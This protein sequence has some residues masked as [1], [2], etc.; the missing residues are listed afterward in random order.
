[1]SPKRKISPLQSREDNNDEAGDTGV[2]R[3]RR[4]ENPHATTTTLQPGD[5]NVQL[6]SGSADPNMKIS[7][8]KRQNGDGNG[9]PIASINL[10]KAI[11]PYN[12]TQRRPAGNGKYIR[13]SQKLFP[14]GNS[15][16]ELVV[17][18]DPLSRT[19]KKHGS[20]CQDLQA[21]HEHEV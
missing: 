6:A 3:R 13:A 17:K 5:Q 1:M 12:S 18:D 14:K 20:S 21:E 11:P 7:P 16:R 4:L 8:F 19:N 9:T 15:G 2:K 10:R